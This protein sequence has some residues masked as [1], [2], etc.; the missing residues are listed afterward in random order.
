MLG[1]VVR[2]VDKDRFVVEMI[3]FESEQGLQT[4]V[5]EVFRASGYNVQLEVVFGTGRADVVARRGS[6]V[7]VV[8]CKNFPR[9]HGIVKSTN[10][11]VGTG[12]AQLLKYLRRMPRAKGLL[13]TSLIPPAPALKFLN[14]LRGDFTIGLGFLMRV[15][16]DI[17]LYA[18]FA[19]GW[20]QGRAIAKA[21]LA[22]VKKH[23]KFVDAWLNR[24]QLF[25]FVFYHLWLQNVHE[26]EALG[27]SREVILALEAVASRRGYVRLGDGTY[28]EPWGVDE[29]W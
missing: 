2:C 15:G 17:V 29:V 13:V 22:K 5:A 27:F 16:S 7:Y 19:S 10:R 3:D 25:D 18:S 6:D 14:F 26:W 4:V 21:P 23:V 28:K 9:E 1:R 8:E 11:T 20:R 24:E 12:L